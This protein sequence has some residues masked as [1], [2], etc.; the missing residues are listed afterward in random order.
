MSAEPRFGGKLWV[1]FPDG[2][3]ANRK[4]EVWRAFAAFGAVRFIYLYKNTQGR[5]EMECPQAALAAKAALDGQELRGLGG[6]VLKVGFR[7]VPVSQR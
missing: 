6:G 3:T 7:Q 2:P 5:L 1:S 4:D